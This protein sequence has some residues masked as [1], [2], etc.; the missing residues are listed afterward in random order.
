MI[1]PI[2]LSDVS[3]AIWALPFLAVTLFATAPAAKAERRP[4]PVYEPAD[5]TVFPQADNLFRGARVTA[6]GQWSDKAP[7]FAVNGN[8]SDPGEHW[9]AENL[10]VWLTV[11][12]GKPTDLNCIRL[13]TYWGDGRSYQYIVEGSTNGTGWTTLADRRESKSP[14][15]SEGDL[16]TF[17]TTTVRYVR[18]TFTGNTAGAKNGGHIVEIEGY[19][20]DDAELEASSAADRAWIAVPSGLRGGVG[21]LNT[22]Y[23]RNGVPA[24]PEGGTWK[25]VGWRGERVNAQMV[26]WS[27]DPINQVR[28]EAGPLTRTDGGGNISVT[29]RFVRYVLADQVLMADILDDP[30]RLNM[31][32]RSTRPVWVSVDI[33]RDAAPGIYEAIVTARAENR[34]SVTFPVRLEVMPLQLPPPRDWSFHLDLWQNPFAVARYHHVKLWSPEHFALLKPHLEMLANAG[35]KC[36]STTIINAPWGGQTYDSYGSMVDWTLAKDGSWKYDYSV[37]DKY[38]EFGAK[39]GLD[40]YI[41]CYSMVPWTNKVQ[42]LDEASGEYREVSIVPGTPEYERIWSPF[43]K[44]FTAHLKRKGWLSRAVIAMDERPLEYMKPAIALLQ[45]QGDGLRLALAGDNEPRVEKDI[46]D[47]CVIIDS[48]IADETIR[49]RT[50]RGV[51][52]TFYVCTGPERPNTFTYSPPAEAAWLGFYAAAR[53]LSG[54]LR[55]AYDSWTEDPLYDTKHVTWQAGDAFLVYPGARSSIRFERLREGIQEY[56]KIRLL[57]KWAGS[58]A[59]AEVKNLDSILATFTYDNAQKSPA[60]DA[61][62]RAEAAIERLSRVVAAGKAR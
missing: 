26:L 33:P 51:L 17:A 11:D 37:F 49:E 4:R 6:S 57:R 16:L 28:L 12:L 24:V 29:A 44:D 42:Y 40:K 23:A 22:R 10:P 32:A 50:R 45:S 35:A 5:P 62:D 61:V 20:L 52:T 3:R 7:E 39:C 30:D 1:G 21:T 19:R 47:W 2:D 14:S 36:L 38:V 43:L 54:F 13:W 27:K 48:A 41:N 56:E 53:N 25:G 59:R 31:A 60:A 46:D 34:Q 18:T 15:T 9:A 58:D 8:H 55:W